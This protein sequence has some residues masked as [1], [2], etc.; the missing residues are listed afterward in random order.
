MGVMAFKGGRLDAQGGQGFD[1][2]GGDEA[3]KLAAEGEA[4]DHGDE[5][6]HHHLDDARAQLREVIEEGHAEHAFFAVAVRIR[7]IG[8]R[9][10]ASPRAAGNGHGGDRPGRRRYFPFG[11]FA[12]LSSS[13]EAIY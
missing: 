7:G 5:H 10:R 2:G 1:G 8:R 4:D 6:A 11:V 9:R 12:P 3:P 13:R